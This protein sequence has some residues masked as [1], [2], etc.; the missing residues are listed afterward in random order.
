M[1]AESV[2]NADV[3]ILSIGAAGRRGSADIITWSRGGGSSVFAGWCGI[4]VITSSTCTASGCGNAADVITSSLDGTGRRGT[5]DV[6]AWSTGIA[7]GCGKAVDVIASCVGTA[8]GRGSIDV[9][10]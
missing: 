10:D 2:N 3:S 4:D 5:I 8:S 6:I 9:I 1:Y 7:S